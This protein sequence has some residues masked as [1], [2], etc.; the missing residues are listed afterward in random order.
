MSCKKNH[1]EANDVMDIISFDQGGAGRHKCAGC[2]YE[3]GY[4]DGYEKRMLIDL[5]SVLHNLDISQSGIRRHRS[6][7]AA[8]ILGY[9]HGLNKKL[10]EGI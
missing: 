8:Y 10:S 2:A 4:K 3:Q 9:F 5:N 6:A 1:G 7:H